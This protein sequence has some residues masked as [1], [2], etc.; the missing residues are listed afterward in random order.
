MTDALSAGTAA[1]AALLSA[2]AVVPDMS[3]ADDAAL[4]QRKLDLKAED[5]F[6]Q[7]GDRFL[8]AKRV[9]PFARRAIDIALPRS[10]V[11]I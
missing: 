6:S 10:I 5:A 8:A 1:G 11:P 4:K 9:D 7:F 2:V 3:L